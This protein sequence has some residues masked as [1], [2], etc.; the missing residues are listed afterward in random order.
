[1]AKSLREFAFSEIRDLVRTD[2]DIFTPG[3]RVSRVLG[4]LKESDHYEAV[5]VS[6]GKVGLVT[7]RD[8]LDVVQPHQ[9]EIGG[10]PK[11]R[12]SVYRAVSPSQTVLEVSEPMIKNRVRAL[13]VVEDGE[14]VGFICQVEIME[15]LGGVK[16][17]SDIPAKDLMRAP[18]VAMGAG[19]GVAS[20]RRAMLDGGFSHVPVVDG[21]RLVGLVTAKD[22][23]HTFITPIGSATTGERIGQKVARFSGTL[24]EIMDAH[25]YTAEPETN[26][27]EVAGRMRELG[28]SACLVAG[29]DGRLFGIITPRELMAPM[30]RFLGEEE[31]PVYI[32]GLS[33]EEYFFDRAV[34]EEKIRRVV[35]RGVEIHPHMAEVSVKVERSSPGGERKRYEVSA[36]VYNYSRGERFA[37]KEE[38][39]DLLRVFDELCDALDRVMRDSKHEPRR[40]SEEERLKRLSY[41][42]GP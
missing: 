26:A 18:V 40:L 16:E 37:V 27:R 20:A 7:V 8:L 29:D 32:V 33:G 17:L 42:R 38:G 2:I 21:G 5:V 22:I 19:E 25:P 10:H 24:G 11:D 15:A 13:P 3:D 30:L 41:M 35:R 4:E 9:T 23:V 39:Y 6:D 28:K 34:A 36:E 1:L 31:L 12:W 14:A